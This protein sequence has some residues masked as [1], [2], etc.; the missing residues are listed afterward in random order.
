MDKILEIINAAQELFRSYGFAKTTMTDIAKRLS[1][2]KASLYYYFKD[3]D[4]IFKALAEK[5]QLQFVGEIDKIKNN[6][7]L[8]KEKLLEYSIKR[9]ELLQRLLTLSSL[10][11]DSYAAVKPLFTSVLLDFRFIE[12]NLVKEIL[13]KGISENEFMEMNIDENAELFLDVLRGLRKVAFSKSEKQETRIISTNE[14]EH[15]KNQ[16]IMF[17]E[18]LINS[19]SK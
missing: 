11:Q 7:A 10:T 18:L 17:T 1:I 16:S 8:A 15:L 9:L 14:Y 5:E 19:I 4:E 12:M 2:S 3:K 6:S 13:Q